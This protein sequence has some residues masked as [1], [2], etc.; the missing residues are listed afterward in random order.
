MFP[1]KADAP[2]KYYEIDSD[3]ELKGTIFV[4]VD[5]TG[6]YASLNNGII[7]IDSSIN[8]NDVLVKFKGIA[9]NARLKKYN[10]F[11]IGYT[12]IAGN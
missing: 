12:H 2:I 9:L 8:Y 4:N 7:Q 5:P 3:I 10:G 6:F 11:N 1:V